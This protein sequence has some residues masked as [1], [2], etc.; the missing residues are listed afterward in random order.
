MG[1]FSDFAFPCFLRN[2]SKK[3]KNYAF[4]Q[5][6]YKFSGRLETDKIKRFAH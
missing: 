3:G 1:N 5:T 6:I 2:K 4:G